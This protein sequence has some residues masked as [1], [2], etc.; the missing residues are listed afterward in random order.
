MQVGV[1][2]AIKT[3]ADQTEP[4]EQ[5]YQTFIQEA[6]LAEELGF[7]FV[8][9][10]EHHF[11]DDAWSP[12]QLPILANIAAQTSRVRLHTNIFLL[13]LHHPLRVSED[14]ATV[15]ILSHG[16][17]DLT[18]GTGSVAEEFVPFGVD[19]KT[20]W[21]RFFEAMEIIRRS[22]EEDSFSFEGKHFQIPDRIRQTTKPVQDPFPLWVG[23]YGAKLQYRAGREGYHSQNGANFH[24]EYLRGL[25]EAGINPASR[26]HG[27]FSIGHL[28][29]S[30]EQAWAECRK[31]WWNR[32]HESRKRTWIFH[33][34]APVLPPLE[35]F[36]K[37]AEPPSDQQ[38]MPPVVGAPE[39]ILYQLRPIYERCD[40]THYCF[41][42]RAC[43]GGMPADKT[44]SAMQLFAR[45]VLPTLRTWGREPTTS[46]AV[47]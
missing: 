46:R 5:V 22:Y 30:V 10:S 34:N 4:L 23:G 24:P 14:A 21:G 42:F 36:E 43:G 39:D 2:L 47:D 9:T 33:P 37:M 26:N 29:N 35:E 8:S 45:E 32:Q 17:L 18:C 3:L 12:S 6:I 1:A 19:Q 44:R 20:R 38:L 16:R 41:F 13:P 28:A 31:A 11:E 7:D 40:T 25:Q 15:D 27:S